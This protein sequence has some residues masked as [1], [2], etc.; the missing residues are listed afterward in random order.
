LSNHGEIAA[1]TVAGKFSPAWFALRFFNKETSGW[2]AGRILIC[3]GKT[4]KELTYCR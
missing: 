4:G 2:L 3:H 1:V